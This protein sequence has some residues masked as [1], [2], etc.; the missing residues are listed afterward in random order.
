MKNQYFGDVN[1]YIEYGILR[2]LSHAGFRIGVCWMLTSDDK[3]PDGRRVN[4]LSQPQNW[5]HH[6]AD[7]FGHLFRTLAAP[8]GKNIRHIEKKGWIHNARFFGK[9]VPDPKSERLRWFEDALTELNGSDLLFFDPDNGIEVPTIPMGRKGS[10]KYV[11]WEDLAKAWE[12][13]R[14]LLVFQHFPRVKRDEFIS[15][16]TQEIKSRLNQSSVV[17]MK[18]PNVLF[19]LA[20]RQGDSPRIRKALNLIDEKW[21]QRVLIVKK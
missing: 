4:Y 11:Y 6:D 15:E 20:Y 8:D 14:S 18:S 19:L 10:S 5:R 2:C 1:D 13:N 21:S 3:R 7:L 9:D 17:P 12:L 16:K